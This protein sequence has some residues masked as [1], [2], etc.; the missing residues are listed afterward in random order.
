MSRFIIFRTV[1]RFIESYILDE[2]HK[3]LLFNTESQNCVE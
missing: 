2:K 1:V 3:R